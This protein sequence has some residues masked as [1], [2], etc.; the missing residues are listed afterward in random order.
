MT[1]MNKIILK[2]MS[3]LNTNSL[4]Q[5]VI[6]YNK[7]IIACFTDMMRPPGMSPD[8]SPGMM[9]PP[10]PMAT[11]PPPVVKAEPVSFVG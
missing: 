4:C 11:A 5:M 3:R 6:H 2:Y 7:C 10:T 8:M 9:N 1:L